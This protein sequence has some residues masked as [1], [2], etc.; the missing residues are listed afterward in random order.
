M[1]LDDAA[2]EFSGVILDVCRDHGTW[3]DSDELERVVG[4][5]LSGALEGIPEPAPSQQSYAA[6]EFTRIIAKEQQGIFSDRHRQESST[7]RQILKTLGELLV[8]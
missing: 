7:L 6:G 8:R 5:I 4:F 3:L 2:Q 1:Q